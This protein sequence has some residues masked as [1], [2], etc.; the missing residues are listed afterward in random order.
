MTKHNEIL[1]KFKSILP[2]FD[3]TNKDHKDVVTMQIHQ[4]HAQKWEN[5]YIHM[6]ALGLGVTVL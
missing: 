3:F 5:P 4:F 2:A 6:V 1:S